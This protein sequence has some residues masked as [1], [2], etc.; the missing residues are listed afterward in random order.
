MAGPVR[1]RC[2]G[3]RGRLVA[4]LAALVLTAVPPAVAAQ[5]GVSAPLPSNAEILRDLQALQLALTIDVR[6][7]D[8]ERVAAEDRLDQL[9][10]EA[11]AL[12]AA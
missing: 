4:L 12:D 1:R 7:I 8:A 3:R 2:V 5:E 6:R 10:A 11:L 9:E